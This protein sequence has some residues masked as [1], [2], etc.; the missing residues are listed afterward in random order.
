[1]DA[2]ATE[3][4]CL[5]VCSSLPVHWQSAAAGSGTLNQVPG[6]PGGS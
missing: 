6:L 4:L 5:G 3:S 2:L 1:M